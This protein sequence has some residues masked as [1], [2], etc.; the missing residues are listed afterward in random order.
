[1]SRRGWREH[2]ACEPLWASV[3]GLAL[4][5]GGA[6]AWGVVGWIVLNLGGTK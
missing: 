1:M 3:L 6:L 4:C 2:G 5:L